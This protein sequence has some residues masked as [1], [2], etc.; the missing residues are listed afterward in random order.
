MKKQ[1]TCRQE[2][3]KGRVELQEGR[4]ACPVVRPEGYFSLLKSP[5]DHPGVDEVGR[6]VPHRVQTITRNPVEL[7]QAQGDDEEQGKGLPAA[8]E[9][10]F[11]KTRS[12]STPQS[13]PKDRKDEQEGE[14]TVDKGGEANGPGL[15]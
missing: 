15:P 2:K 13:P 8:S 14:R 11:Q 10:V 7:D 12:D 3:E 6:P 5:V 1:Q 9:H 4:T